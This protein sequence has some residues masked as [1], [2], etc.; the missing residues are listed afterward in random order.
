M[1]WIRIGIE[2]FDWMRINCMRI[3]NTEAGKTTVKTLRLAFLAVNMSSFPSLCDTCGGVPHLPIYA[4]TMVALN[5]IRTILNCWRKYCLFLLYIT[6]YIL[7][8][9]IIRFMYIVMI[10]FCTHTEQETK[11]LL[12]CLKTSSRLF[13]LIF[14]MHPHYLIIQLFNK[15]FQRLSL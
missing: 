1:S 6:I 10:G 8:D 9:P 2:I 12:L 15:M 14:N 13:H 5:I 4:G 3:R 7:I 11:L